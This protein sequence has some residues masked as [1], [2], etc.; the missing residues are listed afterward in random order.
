MNTTVS[1]VGRAL[2]LGVIGA[3]GHAAGK[4]FP[5]LRELPVQLAAVCDHN[6]AQARR[7]ARVFGA[8]SVYTN[9]AAMLHDADLDA[10]VVC[11][12]GAGHPK[13][14]IEAMETGLPVYTEKPPA[15]SSLDTAVMLEAS[16]RT[17]QICM[18]GFMK[19]FAPVYRR[20]RAAVA[21]EDF[22]A[23]SLLAITW[24]FGVNEQA[25][26]D[27]FLGDFGVHMIDLARYFFG[28]VEEVFARDSGGIAYA[29]TL[30]FASGAVGT[31]SM[32][33][34]RGYD[35]TERTE[36]TGGYGN[37]VSIDSTG[38]LVHYRASVAEL[39]ER[40][41]A[42]QDSLADIGYLGELTE[43]VDAVRTGREPESSIASSHQTM[44]VHDAIHRSA[45]ECRAVRLDEI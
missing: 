3:G 40:P 4:I 11:V 15:E 2:R 31:L 21:A 20:A 18:T 8:E 34:N 9:H 12:G 7:N 37:H 41:L 10:V 42:M 32:T 33:A 22:G 14:A 6:E 38:R 36:L 13:V 45:T 23:P 43:F 1:P 5:C 44:R 24:S 17:G 39:Y 27:V 29:V 19:R 25:W 26:L 35:I 16:R 28:E 30:V